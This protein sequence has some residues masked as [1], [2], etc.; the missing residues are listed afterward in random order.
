MLAD[1]SQRVQEQIERQRGGNAEDKL[2]DL[3]H[4]EELSRKVRQ[5]VVKVLYIRVY[6]TGRFICCRS[7]ISLSMYTAVALI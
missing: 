4:I 7:E 5:K 1:L 6:C 3:R 2:K